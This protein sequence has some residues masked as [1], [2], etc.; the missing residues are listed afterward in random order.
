MSQIINPHFHIHFPIN[1]TPLTSIAMGGLG[2]F[3]A[4]QLTEIAKKRFP[5]LGHYP[6]TLFAFRT[7]V[8][9][10][11]TFIGTTP[12][13]ALAIQIT[14]YICLIL[15]SCNNNTAN[16]QELPCRMRNLT[17]EAKK[18]EPSPLLLNPSTVSELQTILNIEGE[19]NC[20][21]LVGRP[22]CGKTATIETIASQIAH[23]T[24]PEGSFFR[25][26][27]LIYLKVNDLMAQDPNTGTKYAGQTGARIQQIM[28]T[29]KKIP[30]AILVI[31]EFHMLSTGKESNW[32]ESEKP[33]E[34]LKQYVDR[35]ETPII[36]ITTPELYQ[37]MVGNVSD[38]QA[39]TRRFPAIKIPEINSKTCLEMLIH[40]IPVYQKK[41]GT[42]LLE[43][44]AIALAVV[45]SNVEKQ[46]LPARPSYW[47]SKI[48]SS[49]ELL[50]ASKKPK[51]IGFAEMFTC[52]RINYKISQEQQE[53]WQTQALELLAPA[54]SA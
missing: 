35:G 12:H 28:D 42:I 31:D 32:A 48:C 39:I 5:A 36:G 7:V 40:K 19:P 10:G 17:E 11:A 3:A 13:A 1:F 27:I 18:K 37:N 43:P 52:L 25:G 53:A 30:N 14:A 51:Q 44:E 9:I 26:K 33:L 29:L 34:I 54:A 46:T 24:L 4:D 8:A 45:F 16:T 47:L 49:V 6:I 41:L 21:I 2:Y 50:P 20:P 15:Y 23:N 22:G 38:P